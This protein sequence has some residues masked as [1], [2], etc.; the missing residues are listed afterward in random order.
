[1]STIALSPDVSGAAQFTIAAPATATNR[2]LTLPDQTGTLATSV[3]VAAAEGMVLLGTLTMTSGASQSLSGLTLTGYK[4]LFFDV[5]EVSHNNGSST[6]I[7]IGAG[8]IMSAVSAANVINGGATV[9]LWSGLALPQ[10]TRNTLPAA[11]DGV[12]AQTGYSTATT[13][14]TVSV[15]AGAFDLGSIRVYGVK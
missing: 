11:S 14:V 9:S 3:D 2:T 5:N 7:S 13:T 4:Q 15:G 1:M 6:T 8:Q 10:M 12:I